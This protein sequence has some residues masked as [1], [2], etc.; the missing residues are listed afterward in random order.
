M[1]Q[2]YRRPN[3]GGRNIRDA[4]GLKWSFTNQC[5]QDPQISYMGNKLR[6]HTTIRGEQIRADLKETVRIGWKG[7]IRLIEF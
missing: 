1:R 2:I 7:A 6:P 4:R 5:K 3:E